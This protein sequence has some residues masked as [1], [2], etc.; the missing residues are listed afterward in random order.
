[1]GSFEIIR[2]LGRHNTASRISLVMYEDNARKFN[3]VLRAIK[4]DLG[5]QVISLGKVDAMLKVDEALKRGEIIGMLGD[6]TF[7]GEGTVACPFLGG[8]ARFPTGRFAL[9]PR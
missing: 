1:M 2:A 8:Q 3:S 9:P 4:P 6:C 7:K 5:L